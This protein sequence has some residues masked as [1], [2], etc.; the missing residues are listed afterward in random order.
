[1]GHPSV[2]NVVVVVR[3]GVPG[4]KRLVGVRGAGGGSGGQL[5]AS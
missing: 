4:D 3:E 2:R 5:R 1:M